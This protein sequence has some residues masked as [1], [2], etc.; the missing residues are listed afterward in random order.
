MIESYIS[1]LEA[2]VLDDH[3]HIGLLMCALCGVD[4]V[5]R[6]VDLHIGRLG[7]CRWLRL[8]SRVVEGVDLRPERRA[9]IALRSF[10]E[11]KR[12]DE[13]AFAIRDVVQNPVALASCPRL[14]TAFG[15]AADALDVRILRNSHDFIP[16]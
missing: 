14:V 13:L 7:R 16:E 15:T 5:R 6:V 3:L 12:V 9:S 8:S 10:G 2:L 1:L 4:Q 11:G